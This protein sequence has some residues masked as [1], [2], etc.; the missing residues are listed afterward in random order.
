MRPSVLLCS[1]A[2][3]SLLSSA[4]AKDPISWRLEKEEFV[5]YSIKPKPA[6][7]GKAVSARAQRWA[8]FA[9]ELNA[10]GDKWDVRQRTDVAVALALW[11]PDAKLAEGRQ[12]SRK[13]T[14]TIPGMPTLEAT[15]TWRH[16]GKASWAKVEGIK[17]DLIVS[18][19]VTGKATTYTFLGGS[20]KGAVYVHPERGYVLGADI[21]SDLKTEYKST[22]SKH[23]SETI[24]DFTMTVERV[25]SIKSTNLDTLINQAIERGVKGLKG[26][27]AANGGFTGMSS[28]P[29]G[30][31]AICLLALLKS[32]VPSDDPAIVK[33]FKHLDSLPFKQTYDVALLLMATEARYAPS[34]AALRQLKVKERQKALADAAKRI[35][36]A[37]KER[38]A[39][40]VRW[41]IKGADKAK[42]WYPHEGPQYQG[43]SYSDNSNTQYA[44]LGLYAAERSG[45]KTPTSL[46]LE[47]LD[48]F[49]KTQEANGPAVVVLERKGRYAR[50][51]KATARG[52]NYQTTARPTARAISGGSD[53]ETTTAYGSMTAGGIASVAIA[54]DVLLRKKKLSRKL[55]SESLLS[56]RDG[57]A[58]MQRH[59]SVRSNPRYSSWVYYYLYALERAG[60]FTETTHIGEHDWYREGAAVLTSWQ[61]EKGLWGSD[62]QTAFALLFLRKASMPLMTTGK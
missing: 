27:Q 26:K 41:L 61:D 16:A 10:T 40:A 2:L 49:L 43:R 35:S 29:M 50:K 53:Q 30:S 14:F 45:I 22:T 8:G 52:W 51:R 3:V 13:R 12:I 33:G 23:T 6:R 28:H 46:W 39:A 58:W 17:L 15:A 5:A 25:E 44:V 57:I 4:A 31:T 9:Y 24:S 32:G 7:A 21:T 18:F 56:I 11:L 60:I 38:M 47:I 42:W 20:C 19:E 54:R 34:S 1:L 37:D 59:Y 48:Q 62:Y 36:K 55:A